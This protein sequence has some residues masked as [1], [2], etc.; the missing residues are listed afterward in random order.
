MGTKGVP[1]GYLEFS[2]EFGGEPCLQAHALPPPP[3]RPSAGAGVRNSK[4][5]SGHG[6]G[7]GWVRY[8]LNRVIRVWV[9]GY[10]HEPDPNH[11][12]TGCANADHLTLIQSPDVGA[13]SPGAGVGWVRFFLNQVTGVW[14]SRYGHELDSNHAHAGCANADHPTRP[15]HT[16]F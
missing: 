15:I 7:V 2:C 12:D 8:F 9:S 13:R 4:P 16:L 6:R 14:V 10:G 11:A 5:V 1:F 3:S